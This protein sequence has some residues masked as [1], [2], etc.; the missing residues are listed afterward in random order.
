M[1]YKFSFS[2]KNELI[3]V[4]DTPHIQA[5]GALLREIIDI[6]WELG[7]DIAHTSIAASSR[8]DSNTLI[9][10]KEEFIARITHPA[11]IDYI[12]KIPSFENLCNE[13]ERF[14]NAYKVILH[15]LESLIDEEQNSYEEQLYYIISS[16]ESTDIKRFLDT[17]GIANMLSVHE[18]YK[19]LYQETEE[20][21]FLFETD[22]LLSLVI[23][24]LQFICVNRFYIRKCV[25]CKRFLWTRKMNKIYCD[26]PQPN[27]KKTCSQIGPVKLWLNRKP[28]AYSLYWSY[29]KRLFTRMTGDGNV[30]SYN[31]WLCE[32]ERYRDMAKNDE[33]D[34][35]EM[36]T[37]LDQIE[38]EIYKKAVCL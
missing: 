13:L 16:E 38:A 33:I 7:K 1:I 3:Y 36:K 30:Y 27:T 11:L 26:R 15:I 17:L 6:D 28:K 34:F 23:Q 4:S 8:D 25:H 37:V 12:N 18:R 5:V 20:Y 19:P 35:E 22:D 24:E 2:Q 21:P 29:R 31:Q 14:G 10:L 9:K 32:T